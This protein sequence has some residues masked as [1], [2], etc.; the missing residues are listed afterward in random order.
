MPAEMRQHNVSI[1]QTWMPLPLHCKTLRQTQEAWQQMQRA[2][3]ERSM[4]N[5]SCGLR[6][7]RPCM[8]SRREC[9]NCHWSS[10]FRPSYGYRRRWTWFMEKRHQRS[11]RPS[12]ELRRNFRQRNIRPIWHHSPQAEKKVAHHSYT[13]CASI[14][15]MLPHVSWFSFW[16]KPSDRSGCRRV[17]EKTLKGV[18]IAL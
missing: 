14:E 5:Q 4:E 3:Q 8:G 9:S 7:Q 10:L 1:N 6:F 15:I 2:L 16:Q 13:F 11:G 12:Q 17:Y 18:S